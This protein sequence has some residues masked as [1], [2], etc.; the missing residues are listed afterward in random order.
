MPLGLRP[1]AR[2]LGISHVALLKAATTGRVKRLSDGTFDV[3]AC[4]ADLAQNSHPV[5]SRSARAQQTRGPE[6]IPEAAISPID[7]PTGSGPTDEGPAP[8]F[9][10]RLAA[11]PDE[12]SVAE[13]TRLLEWERLREKRLKVDREEGKLVDV[14][15]VNAFVAGM[16]LEAR[17]EL[18]RIPTEMRDLLAHETDPIQCEALL[19][20][21]IQSVLGKLSEYRRESR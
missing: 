3:E 13:A 14:A 21:R 6:P 19:S 16:I 7:T 5:K 20:L 8:L 17:D 12:G 10:E 2:E 4:R 1:A 11:L 15:A 9:E 18:T